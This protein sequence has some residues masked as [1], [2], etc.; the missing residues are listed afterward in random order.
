MTPIT[1]TFDLA[2]GEM[3]QVR[4]TLDFDSFH[5]MPYA[6]LTV[7]FQWHDAIQIRTELVNVGRLL[8]LANAAAKNIESQNYATA[9]ATFKGILQDWT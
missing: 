1:L 8:M 2:A 6:I 4:A 7:R 5:Q 9:E 3:H